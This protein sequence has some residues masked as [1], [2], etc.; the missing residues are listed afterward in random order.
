MREVITIIYLADGAKVT[1]P[2]NKFQQADLK[3]W[4]MDTPV[5]STID[6]ELNPLVL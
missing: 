5:G 3:T 1:E 2:Q 4:M 6:T